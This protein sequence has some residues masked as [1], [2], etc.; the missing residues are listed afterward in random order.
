MSS[1]GIFAKK[2]CQLSSGDLIADRRFSYA[3]DYAD[4]GDHLAACELLEQALERAPTWAA[5]WFALGEARVALNRR[6]A[7]AAAYAQALAAAPDDALGAS[8]KLAQLSAEPPP[9]FAPE[10][11]VKSLFDDY[12]DRFEAHLVGRLAYRGPQLLADALASL[13]GASFKQAIDLGCG[14]GLCGEVFRARVR[15]LAGVDLS[16]RMIARARTKRIYDRLSVQAILAF[17]AAEPAASVD[18][19]LAAEV[20][21][22]FGDLR[23]LFAAAQRVLCAGGLFAVTAQS[24]ASGFRLGADLRYA[25]AP[26]YICE[27]AREAGFSLRFLD[28]A[29]ARREDGRDVPGLVA[30]L[31]K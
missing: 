21:V 20:V 1:S 29:P 28:E 22:Y 10:A 30:V 16:S 25:H 17:L 18:L 24:A 13:G 14:T 4:A 15:H 23:R 27:V 31:A 6:D 19:L 8:L 7:A 9:D 11:Y 26:S 3:A 2:P 5:A 12:A